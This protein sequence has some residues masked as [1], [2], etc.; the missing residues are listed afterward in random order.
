M[1]GAAT[2]T[3]ARP[4]VRPRRAGE[5]MAAGAVIPYDAVA[6]FRITGRAGNL[7]QDVIN[8]STDGVFVATAIGYGFEEE[9]ERAV[10]APASMLPITPASPPVIVGDL[11]LKDLP[12]AALVEG[13][14]VNPLYT[15]WVTGA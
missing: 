11:T 6:T 15:H 7:L 3:R 13:F 12:L 5:G 1:F 14:R 9:R 8:I 4:Q 2:G 10:P